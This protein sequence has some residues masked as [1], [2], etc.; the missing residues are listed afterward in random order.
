M[1]LHEEIDLN[2]GSHMY[3]VNIT[4]REILL[5]SEL[6]RTLPV[7]LTASPLL[8]DKFVILSMVCKAIED[9]QDAPL[10]TQQEFDL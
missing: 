9:K 6:G 10:S 3:V 8:S 4:A 1:T 2:T 5:V 7:E